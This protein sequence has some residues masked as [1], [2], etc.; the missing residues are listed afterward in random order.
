MK[1]QHGSALIISLLI[2]LVM[3]IIGIS[4]MSSSTME[5]KMAANDRN[6]K[7]IF[8][9]AESSLMAAENAVLLLDYDTLKAKLTSDPAT[10]G[11]YTPDDGRFDYLN[12]SAW[13]SDANCVSIANNSN[14]SG[15]SCYIVEEIEGGT[16]FTPGEAAE[17]G[18]VP[19][20]K[21]QIT[22]VTVRS[23]DS[24]NA[25]AVIVQ[26]NLQKTITN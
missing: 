5:E 16:L 14:N 9:N 13:K 23:S 11:Y 6:Q 1:Q 12:H 7:A 19:L 20:P 3:T 21:L 15:S 17:Y 4:A 2:L 10:P 24:N 8:Q 26:S 22:R 25:S 18:S